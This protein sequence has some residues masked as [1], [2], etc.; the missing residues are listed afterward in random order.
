MQLNQLRLLNRVGGISQLLIVPAA[1]R[2]WYLEAVL[3]Q[4]N[5]VRLI[6]S[7]TGEDGE[8]YPERV[9]SIADSAIKAAAS[10]GFSEVTVQLPADSVSGQ[11]ELALTGE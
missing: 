1:S 5:R 6:K 10:I 7:R 3:P 11:E 8:S 9:F 2:G 4:G